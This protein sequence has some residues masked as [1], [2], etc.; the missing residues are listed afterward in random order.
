MGERSNGMCVEEHFIVD[1]DLDNDLNN[2]VVLV[3]SCRGHSK[4]K[5][6][7]SFTGKEAVEAYK[8]LIGKDVD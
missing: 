1:V 8:R 4:P 2:C 5:L 7:K 6:V 3:Y